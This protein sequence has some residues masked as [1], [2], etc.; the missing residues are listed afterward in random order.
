MSALSIDSVSLLVTRG[1][2]FSF[3][4]PPPIR[5]VPISTLPRFLVRS[6]P[7]TRGAEYTA[8]SPSPRCRVVKFAATD[9]QTLL[10]PITESRSSVLAPTWL[11]W[12]QDA[13]STETEAMVSRPRTTTT[14]GLAI[15]SEGPPPPR[16]P[17]P[18]ARP[19]PMA[20]ALRTASTPGTRSRDLYKGRRCTPHSAPPA[21]HKR[22][23]LTCSR[24]VLNIGVGA[25]RSSPLPKTPST[26]WNHQAFL[27][28][29]A[30][31][32]MLVVCRCGK[33]KRARTYLAADLVSEFHRAAVIG[34]LWGCCP[35]CGS[36]EHWGEQERY[37][38]HDDVG[39]LV[40][41][42]PN[43]WRQVRLWRDELY[44]PPVLGVKEDQPSNQPF[45]NE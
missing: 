5:T 30:K 39:H 16:S 40:V 21:L 31:A 45:E 32:G 12:S 7:S 43:G 3:R 42:R 10:A 25:S 14:C 29:A 6:S 38:C 36:V 27:W 11:Q 1:G 41:R 20:P 23:R 4:S 22:H 26:G 44:E 28:R 17:T 8:S 2:A 37:P 35:R 15:C 19:A 24:Y 34:E 33:C 18:L 9:R 13:R